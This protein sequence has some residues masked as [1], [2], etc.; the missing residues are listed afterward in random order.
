VDADLDRLCLRWRT[1]SSFATAPGTSSRYRSPTRRASGYPILMECPVPRQTA[2]TWLSW[3]NR[4][5]TR[6]ATF[7]Y[8]FGVMVVAEYAEGDPMPLP[9]LIA[10]TSRRSFDA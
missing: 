8:D 5:R 7:V 2:A 6:P 3:A 9:G 10:T 4:E 1:W